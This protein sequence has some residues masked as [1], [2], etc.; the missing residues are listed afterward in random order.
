M[1]FGEI[2][3]RKMIPKERA[4]LPKR[5][6]K[7]KKEKKKKTVFKEKEYSITNTKCPW[8]IPMPPSVRDTVMD[9]KTQIVR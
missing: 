9:R 6:L 7:K 3:L 1:Q 5:L 8:V 2:S 4:P